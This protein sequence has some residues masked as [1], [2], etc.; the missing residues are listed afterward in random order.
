LGHP[1]ILGFAA[2]IDKSARLTVLSG[3]LHTAGQATGPLIAGMLIFNGDFSYV[4]WLGVG[5][6]ATTVLLFIPVLILGYQESK[7]SP[8]SAS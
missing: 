2:K 4:L 8:E 6:F 1:Y 3:A 5:A 7:L